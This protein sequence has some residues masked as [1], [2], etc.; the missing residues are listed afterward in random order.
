MQGRIQPLSDCS[1]GEIAGSLV[2]GVSVGGFFLP[3][4]LV[5]RVYSNNQRQLYWEIVRPCFVAWCL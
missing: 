4:P 2:R 1:D 5:L 3:Y